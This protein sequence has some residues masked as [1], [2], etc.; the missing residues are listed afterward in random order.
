MLASL[1]KTKSDSAT[2][3]L[4]GERS[5]LMHGNVTIEVKIN[6]SYSKT[7]EDHILKVPFYT[8]SIQN[9]LRKRTTSL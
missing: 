3:F 5:G 7:K 6:Y 2:P 1:D 4:K 9:N 8:H